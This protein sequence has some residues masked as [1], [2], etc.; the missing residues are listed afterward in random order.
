MTCML[1]DIALYR[2]CRN[3]W[4]LA[5]HIYIDM[6]CSY[7]T[8]SSKK[9]HNTF[10]DEIVSEKSERCMRDDVLYVCRVP[11]CTVFFR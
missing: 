7:C 1:S 10:G 3:S 11:L 6:L 9:Q 8:L 2:N 5:A 4:W